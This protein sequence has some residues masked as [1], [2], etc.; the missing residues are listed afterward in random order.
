MHLTGQLVNLTVGRVKG[1]WF[2]GGRFLACA[3]LL[4]VGASRSARWRHCV[5]PAKRASRRS[6][7]EHRRQVLAQAGYLRVELHAIRHHR[8]EHR[9]RGTELFHRPQRVVLTGLHEA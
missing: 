2:R 1:F 3:V 4:R 8:I 9:Q 6:S 5:A 7:P